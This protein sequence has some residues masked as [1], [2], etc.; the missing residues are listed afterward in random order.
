[1]IH[2]IVQIERDIMTGRITTTCLAAAVILLM[3]GADALA[4]AKKGPVRVF[5]LAGQSNM[6]GKGAIRHLD[7][8]IADPKTAGTY[9]HLK[10]GGKWVERD[11]VWVNFT[12]KGLGRGPAGWKIQPGKFQANKR[13][14]LTVGYGVPGNRIGPELGFGH[15]VGNGLGE[16][17]L[18]IKWAWGGNA[19]ALGFRPPSSFP[20]SDASAPKPGTYPQPTKYYKELGGDAG[21]IGIN[22]KNMVLE[23]HEVLEN[24]GEH[25]PDYDG[26][27]YELAGFVW[28]QG[29]NDIIKK[30]RL[31]EYETNLKHLM[32]DLRTDLG[33]PNLPFVIGELGMGGPVDKPTGNRL[34]FL[35]AQL[36]AIKAAKSPAVW[37]NTSRYVV[38]KSID[39]KSFDGG[40]HYRG[41]ADT[42]YKIGEAFGVAALKLVKEKPVN[43]AAQMK[44]AHAELIV[45][46]GS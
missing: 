45:K 19:L 13:G 21:R 27:G 23:V 7:E 11:D 35:N 44:K 14:K 8:L 18:I 3:G 33:V 9:K 4:E 1:M 22:Y 6:E 24:L 17:V 37:V 43:H 16:Q 2:H 25:F 10:S 20:V 46:Y 36:A 38:P 40:F 34:T 15:A 41:R 29:Y 30:E 32:G 26:S 31:A 12:M 28:F 42:F 5:I 39:P